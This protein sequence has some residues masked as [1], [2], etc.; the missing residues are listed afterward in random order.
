MRAAVQFALMG[1]V[2]GWVASAAGQVVPWSELYD[3]SPNEEVAARGLKWETAAAHVW[4]VSQV[5]HV[6]GVDWQFSCGPATLVLGVSGRVPVWAVLLPDKPGELSAAEPPDAQ[7]MGVVN[8]WLRFHPSLLPEL[9][10][11]ALLDGRATEDVP[12]EIFVAKRIANWKL[13]NSF[14]IGN[15]CTLP[16][17]HQWVVDCDTIRRT[18]WFFLHDR[19]LNTT[20]F[21]PALLR[22][23]VAPP[24][25]LTSV[26]AV[27]AFDVTWRAFDTEY[28]QFVVKPD[29]DWNALREVYRPRAAQADNNVKLAQLLAEMLSKLED[30]HVTVRIGG[31]YF[32]VYERDRVFNAS[33]PAVDQYVPAQEEYRRVLYAGETK[34]GLG[35]IAI[36][37]LQ[38]PEVVKFFDNA[39]E[40]LEDTPGLILDLRYNGGGNETLGR[41][42]A[43]AFVDQP[44]VYSYSRIRSG[45]AHDDLT[46]PQPREVGPREKRYEKPVYVLIGEYTMSSAE[47]LAYMLQQAPNVELYGA[48]TAGSSG[49]PRVLELVGN[50]RVTVPQWL[51]LGPDMQPINQRGVQPDIRAEFDADAFTSEQDPVLSGALEALE[52]AALPDGPPR[53]TLSR[54]V[55]MPGI[56]G[57]ARLTGENLLCSHDLKFVEG[58]AYFGVLLHRQGEPLEYETVEFEWGAHPRGNDIESLARVQRRP[59]LYLAAESGYHN[60]NFGRVFLIQIRIDQN[61]WRGAVA[62]VWQLPRDVKNI[63]GLAFIEETEDSYKIVLGE[64]GGGSQKR[65]GRLRIA[66]LP[67]GGGEVVE[68]AAQAITA[69]GWPADAEV[70]HISGLIFDRQQR[71]WASSASDPGADGPFRTR[72]YCLGPITDEGAALADQL[73]VAYDLPGLKV[74]ALAPGLRSKAPLSIATDDESYGGLWRPL[75]ALFDE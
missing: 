23:P 33:W 27:Q 52:Q 73:K 12:R 70:R 48:P 54:A 22:Q 28:A 59:G 30:L 67:K 55:S 7:A 13:G 46:E 20:R 5:E 6:N 31:E 61:T 45:P 14:H 10:P 53:P 40:D 66:K 32:P 34:N 75:P 4:R 1:L 43:G 18:R 24:F 17:K 42:I 57:I 49:N 29:V 25:K 65:P 47:S 72:I 68:L 62:E 37:S 36:M 64:R 3:L 58:G 26:Q 74:E 60:G 39:L 8:L 41:G 9:F 16:P 56:S 19:Q 38:H 15:R 35:Y 63:E 2:G 51:D 69:P 44:Y 50:I 71:L 11:E 21:I